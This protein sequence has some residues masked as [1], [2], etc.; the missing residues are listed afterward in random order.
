[1]IKMICSIAEYFRL[2]TVDS[3]VLSHSVERHDLL[4][5]PAYSWT[6]VASNF[7]FMA[8]IE[9]IELMELVWSLNVQ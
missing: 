3:T 7:I 1:M 9:S 4:T 5:D 8:L 6:E 2:N